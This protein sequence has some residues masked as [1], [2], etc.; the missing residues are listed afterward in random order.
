LAPSSLFSFCSLSSFSSLHLH[1]LTQL[2]LFLSCLPSWF[3]VLVLLKFKQPDLQSRT[4][5][6]PMTRSHSLHPILFHLCS[7]IEI[8][9]V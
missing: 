6:R 9:Q 1:L 4:A 8:C 3:V 7:K 5:Y 2:E